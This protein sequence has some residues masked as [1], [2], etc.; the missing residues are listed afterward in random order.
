MDG[1]PSVGKVFTGSR[2]TEQK[3]ETCKAN[4]NN[5]LRNNF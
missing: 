2:E 5:V 1:K 3:G 4:Q